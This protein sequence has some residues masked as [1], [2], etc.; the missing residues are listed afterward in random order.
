MAVGQVPRK[1]TLA[2]SLNHLVCAH[3]NV[4]RYTYGSSAAVMTA[5]AMRVVYRA[6]EVALRAGVIEW[7]VDAELCPDRMG[8]KFGILGNLRFQWHK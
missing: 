5:Y 1:L 7:L 6:S 3:A 2:G 8:P 4:G